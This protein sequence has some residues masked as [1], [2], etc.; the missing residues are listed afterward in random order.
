MSGLILSE[1]VTFPWMDIVMTARKPDTPFAPRVV[2]ARRWHSLAV[3]G[4]TVGLVV[5]TSA[6]A[7]QAAPVAIWLAQSTVEGG[8]GGE[9]GAAPDAQTEAEAD[10]G[11]L[12]A[13]GRI[14]GYLRVGMALYGG[15]L[16]DMAKTHMKRPTDKIYADLE[17]ALAERDVAGFADALTALATAVETAAPLAEV[18][19]AFETVL[20]ALAAA[21]SA[22]SGPRHAFDALILITRDAA[23]DYG[24]GVVDGKI[25]DLHE[26]QDAWGFMQAARAMAE[27]LRASDDPQTKAAADK[28]LAAI[29]ATDA[30]FAGLAP[31]GTVPGDATV[32]QGAAARIEFAA[33]SVK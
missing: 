6:I 12:A 23:E 29:L 9:G 27:A 33:L 30:A 16:A 20:A 4:A 13:L 15:G 3:A 31:E 7:E 26:Y 1:R 8:E 19:P 24:A 14:E 21:R 11:Y 5:G 2:A 17:P 28:A 10:A 32:F 22:E 25:V 18:T